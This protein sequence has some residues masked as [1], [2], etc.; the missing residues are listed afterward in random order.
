QLVDRAHTSS[1][2]AIEIA[3]SVA[4]QAAHGTIAI[5]AP[6]AGI[7]RGEGAVRG[8]LEYGAVAVDA[9]AVCLCAVQTA[10]PVPEQWG[11]G[12]SAIKAGNDMQYSEGAIRRQFVNLAAF[13]LAVYK[14]KIAGA[15]QVAGGRIDRHLSGSGAVGCA[16]ERVEDRLGP[17]PRYFEDGPVVVSAAVFGGAVKIAGAVEHHANSVLRAGAGR[18]AVVRRTAKTVDHPQVVGLRLCAGSESGQRDDRS[19]QRAAK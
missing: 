16:G 17:V 7:Q 9:G 8:E 10:L 1:V 14:K 5:G 15:I 4:D 12:A 2:N 3:G 19:Q 13:G 6:G 18:A 11:N